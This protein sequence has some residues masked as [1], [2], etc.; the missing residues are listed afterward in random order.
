MSRSTVSDEDIPTSGSRSR[1]PTGGV[2]AASTEPVAP[3]TLA[4]LP[5]GP[6]PPDT[7]DD[8]GTT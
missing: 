1:E 8:G 5:A 4:Q 3:T 6:V 7:G 2:P